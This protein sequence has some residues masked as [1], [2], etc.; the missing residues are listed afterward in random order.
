MRT[1]LAAGLS[2]LIALAFGP[3]AIKAQSVVTVDIQDFAFQPHE[4]TIQAGTIVHWV[5]HDDWPHHVAAEDGK[6]FNSGVIAPQKDYRATFSQAGRFS[7]RCGI[8]PTMLGV[9]TV[10]GQ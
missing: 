2:F 9:I 7:Y 3:P 4:W 8:H 5:N 1:A 10:Q 6:S